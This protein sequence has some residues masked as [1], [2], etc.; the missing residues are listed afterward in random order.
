MS[1]SRF[2]SLL[3]ATVCLFVTSAARAAVGILPIPDQT[4]PSG[5]TVVVP[6]PAADPDGPAR[7]YTVTISSTGSGVAGAGGVVGHLAVSASAGILAV[8]RT[9]DPHLVVGVA[10]TDS[11]NG[12]PYET[13]TMEFQMLREFAPVTTDVIGGLAQGGY[14]D[15]ELDYTTGTDGMVTTSTNY[16]VFGRV[17]PQ[18]V[19]QLGTPGGGDGRGPGGNPGFHILD[20]Y[21]PAL[22]FSGTFGQLAMA[23]GGTNIDGATNS[24]QYF[25]TLAQERSL[26]FG[27]TIFGQLIRG[28]DVLNGIAATPINPNQPVQVGSGAEYS[29][30]LY[31]VNIIS[32]AVV[33]NNTDAVLLLS[34]TGLGSATI[35]V[36][37][38][39][40][41]SVMAT[42]SFN[43]MAVADVT[44]D[45]PILK[46]VPDTATTASDLKLL[47][48]GTDLQMD[49]LLYGFQK[50]LPAQDPSE[51]SGTSPLFTVPLYPHAA[52]T[53]VAVLDHYDVAPTINGT[54]TNNGPDQRIFHVGAGE[55]PL[56]GTLTAPPVG[57]N[58]GLF[59]PNYTVANITAGTSRDTPASLTGTVNWGDGQ[60][61]TGNELAFVSEGSSRFKL[62]AG[63]HIYKHAGEYPMIVDVADTGGSHLTLTGTAHA[64][65]SSIGLIANPLTVSGSAVAN[66]VVANFTDNGDVSTAA[67]YTATINWGDGTA[68]AGTVKAGKSAYSFQVLG[69][70]TYSEAN[71]FTVS[72]TVSRT[73]S[74]GGYSAAERAM[75]QVGTTPFDADLPPFAQAHLAQIWSQPLFTA[76]NGIDT[77]G[78]DGGTP[79]AALVRGTNGLFYGTT[80]HGGVDGEGTVYQVDMTGSTAVLYSFTG[81]SDGASPLGSLIFAGTNGLL[82]GTVRTDGTGGPG[83]IFSVSTSGSFT[84]LHDFS[85]LTNGENADGASPYSSLVAGTDGALYGT[86][87]AGG[88]HGYGTIFKI[89]PGGV[90]TTLYSFTNGMDGGT[91]D[92]SLV[93]A[94][95][96]SLY[97]TANVSGT[98]GSG[99]VFQFIPDG[100]G[101]GGTLNTVHDFAL[102]GTD[103]ANPQAG[104]VTGTDGNLYGVTSSG[105]DA[106][107][108]TI[109]RV[110]PGIPGGNFTLLASFEGNNGQ[111]PVSPLVQGSDGTFYGTAVY[112]GTSG[113]GVVFAYTPANGIAPIY[114]FDGLSDGQ[115]PFGGVIFGSDGNLYGTTS[116]GGL[117][118]GTVFQVSTAGTLNT[119]HQFAYGQGSQAALIGSVAIVN[120]GNRVSAPGSFSVYADPN[121]EDDSYSE[122]LSGGAVAFTSNGQ[123]AL[124]I[125]ALAPGQSVVFK[126][127]VQGSVSNTELLLPVGF[128]PG[129][130]DIVGVVTYDDPVANFDGASKIFVPASF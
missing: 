13:G 22:I 102:S 126:F 81:G 70:H 36:N 75:A 38:I 90:F 6:V 129:T 77:T 74:N 47:L 92:S 54:K 41:G 53:L 106:G 71:T 122:S 26:D 130:D 86:A 103:G 114:S 82:Y 43:A 121:G 7:S 101:T 105:G 91:P 23:N 69:S 87:L 42:G 33:T 39:V 128:M 44:N 2:T 14:Y 65:P 35:T 9:G 120:S 1:S 107:E 24:S 5:K 50:L 80:E 60:L 64:S 117:G 89:T 18:F 27:H 93:I 29:A 25:I 61:S 83:S 31:P 66:Q 17:V 109:F 112:G 19:V 124:P 37:A 63:P 30:P 98:T 3:L 84:T 99:T 68:S 78:T 49:L 16:V 52:N 20:E 94:A 15:P 67:D 125:P 34:A 104:L 40:G 108:G 95:D 45:S 127:S 8:I 119:I 100:A 62:V 59:L 4:I 51:T 110:T 96:G 118:F 97:G 32:N 73:D 111:T 113:D 12:M 85:G 116:A 115:N 55:N 21:N 76:T 10:Y 46:P 56:K 58:G 48:S 88:A 79:A 11:T 57:Y 123:T 28:A 72:T